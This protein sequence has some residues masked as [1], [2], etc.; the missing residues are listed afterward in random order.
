MLDI[1]NALLGSTLDKAIEIALHNLDKHRKQQSYLNACKNVLDKYETAYSRDVLYNSLKTPRFTHMRYLKIIL[2]RPYP[3]RELFFDIIKYICSLTGLEQN[4]ERIKNF[5]SIFISELFYTDGFQHII[6]L[7]RHDQEMNE[8]NQNIYKILDKL[9]EIGQQIDKAVV[10][11]PKHQE[12]LFIDNKIQKGLLDS[13][14]K[15]KIRR[16]RFFSGPKTMTMPPIVPVSYS[17]VFR[18]SEIKCVFFKADI[19]P[20]WSAE[21]IKVRLWVYDETD[22]LFSSETIM[23][24]SYGTNTIYYGFGYDNK[25]E[26]VPGTYRYKIQIEDSFFYEAQFVVL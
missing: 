11:L 4:D 25:D 17:T 21:R 12:N 20:I 9:E 3:S 16:I 14:S 24:T 23:E 1:A 19:V 13:P 22:E 18:S 2:D 6:A 8:V 26:F 7:Y 15:F 10:K 5:I